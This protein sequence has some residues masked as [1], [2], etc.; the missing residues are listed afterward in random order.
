VAKNPDGT[1]NDEKSQGSLNKDKHP[2]WEIQDYVEKLNGPGSFRVGKA[3]YE[4]SKKEKISGAKQL[5]VF[6][7]ATSRVFTGPGVRALIGLPDAD[8][9]VAP[10]FNP[11]Y[12]IFV[13]SQ[14]HNR[15]LVV[16]TKI[17]VLN[18]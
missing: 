15:H 17:L 10:D 14:S 6:E 1:R 9:T 11:S 3:F 18:N 4:L 7:V 12:K 5:A 2:V 16:G 8:A 13:Q